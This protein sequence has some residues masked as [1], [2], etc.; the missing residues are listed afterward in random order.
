MRIG[1]ITN[2]L[3]LVVM[4]QFT[5]R[6]VG[7]AVH[8]ALWTAWHCAEC[9]I[10]R[11]MRRHCR[12]ISVPTMIVVSFHQ[13]QANLRVLEVQEIKTGPTFLSLIRS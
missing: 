1:D 13:W 5:R 11:F 4:D 6:I 9:S 3:G 12:N 8:G 10:A 7:L 2:V